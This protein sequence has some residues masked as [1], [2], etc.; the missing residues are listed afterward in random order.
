MPAPVVLEKVELGYRLKALVNIHGIKDVDID[1]L[2]EL[3]VCVR[4]EFD[5]V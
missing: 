1:R 2:T 5:I 3:G 4:G